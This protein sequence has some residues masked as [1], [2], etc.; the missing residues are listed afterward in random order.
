MKIMSGYLG[1]GDVHSGNLFVR[2]GKGHE[3][4]HTGFV[5]HST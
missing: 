1:G 3:R 2:M 4:E 5:W